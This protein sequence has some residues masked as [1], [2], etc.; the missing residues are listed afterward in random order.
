MHQR[1]FPVGMV[2]LGRLASVVF[3]ATLGVLGGPSPAPGEPA[4]EQYVCSEPPGEERSDATVYHFVFQEGGWFRNARFVW[5]D[6]GVG[7]QITIDSRD[8]IEGEVAST[9]RMP[10]RMAIDQCLSDELER[11]PAF[12]LDAVRVRCQHHAALSPEPVPIKLVVDIDR[13]TGAFKVIRAQ[14][15]KL[16]RYNTEAYGTCTRP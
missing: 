14:S 12:D 4:P 7:L 2:P 11:Q 9:D 6:R 1:T 5:V 3:L 10:D 15:K 8:L 13:R 16:A